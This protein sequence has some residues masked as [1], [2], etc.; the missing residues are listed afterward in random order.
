MASKLAGTRARNTSKK[1]MD[2][3]IPATILGN[4][5]SEDP[6]WARSE[7][8]ESPVKAAEIARKE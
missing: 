1:D 6:R 5:T 7:P 4:P 8:M 2:A 3:D